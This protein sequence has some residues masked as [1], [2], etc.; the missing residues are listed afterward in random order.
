MFDPGGE[1][2]WCIAAAAGGL[3]D[4]AIQLLLNGFDLSCVSWGEVAGSAALSGL[5]LGLASELVEAGKIGKLVQKAQPGCVTYRFAKIKDVLRLEA[6][7]IR[8]TWPNW[9]NW[10]HWHLDAISGMSKYHLPI[11]EPLVAGGA[12]LKNRGDSDC[13]CK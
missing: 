5:T 13:N 4:L 3:S 9:A 2:P 7:P 11:I 6:H 1:C 8:S 10:S 12:L